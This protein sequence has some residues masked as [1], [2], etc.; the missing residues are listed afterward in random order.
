MSAGHHSF[1][2]AGGGV[3]DDLLRIKN[4][5]TFPSSES[6]DKTVTFRKVF[7][8]IDPLFT[9]Q[10]LKGSSGKKSTSLL[11]ERGRGWERKRPLLEEQKHG[12][13]PEQT[14]NKATTEAKGLI[15]SYSDVRSDKDRQGSTAAE[16]RHTRRSNNHYKGRKRTIGR[17]DRGDGDES[18]Q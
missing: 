8:F 16:Q 14:Y 13:I 18:T 15:G 2:P 6:E 4:N 7:C 10:I 9:R 17:K 11:R 5:H 3:Y 12:N 1:I